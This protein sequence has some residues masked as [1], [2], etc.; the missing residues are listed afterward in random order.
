[1]ENEKSSAQNAFMGLSRE[2]I[3]KIVYEELSKSG[4][5]FNNF[6]TMIPS[7][8]GR[9]IV[10]SGATVGNYWADMFIKGMVGNFFKR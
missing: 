9:V 3:A 6:N 2:Q 4:F 10:G 8:I 1:M 5:Q 7:I